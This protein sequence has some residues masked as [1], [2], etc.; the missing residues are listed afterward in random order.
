MDRQILV[1]Q[2]ADAHNGPIVSLNFLIGEA[3]F[4]SSGT[5]NRLI[6]WIL[7]DELALPEEVKTIEGPSAPVS[8]NLQKRVS[9]I[10]Y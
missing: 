6:K 2:K 4:I 10:C 5:D 7:K 3:F 1:G 9:E 8:F